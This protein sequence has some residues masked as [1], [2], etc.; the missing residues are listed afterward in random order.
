MR[1]WGCGATCVGAETPTPPPH[2]TPPHPAPRA[3]RHGSP[4]HPATPPTGIH[5]HCVCVGSAAYPADVRWLPAVT[6]VSRVPPAPRYYW[7]QPA[8]VVG[9]H[10]HRQLCKGQVPGGP[11]G[12]QP[13]VRHQPRAGA[14]GAQQA[15]Q[16]AVVLRRHVRLA[17]HHV[18]R[19]ETQDVQD[20]APHEPQ[21]AHGAGLPR[22]KGGGEEGCEGRKRKRRV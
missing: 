14:H 13:R 16:G 22:V 15:S 19:G 4:P 17:H 3:P 1:W 21:G 7:H 11:D 6:L 18:R 12:R 5:R 9:R 20:V 8:P 2:R 10:V